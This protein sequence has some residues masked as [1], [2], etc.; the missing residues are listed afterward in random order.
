MSLLCS[1]F[2]SLCLGVFLE[3]EELY[4][5]FSNNKDMVH[6]TLERLFGDGLVN[7]DMRSNDKK[8]GFKQYRVFYCGQLFKQLEPPPEA[9]SEVGQENGQKSDS[10]Q[11]KK[12]SDI[13]TLAGG[14]LDK[15][16]PVQLNFDHT[17]NNCQ[18][19][20]HCE[21]FE[22]GDKVIWNDAPAH[23]SPWNPFLVMS[24][25]TETTT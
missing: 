21:H 13:E 2:L 15:T 5:G 10:N 4:L 23:V 1:C 18:T 17:S 8:R 20:Y 11:E 6:K 3:L 25:D 16:E 9:S 24:I 14:K 12:L 19:I 22:V 7:A